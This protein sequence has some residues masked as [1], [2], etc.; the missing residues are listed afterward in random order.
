MLMYVIW[1]LDYTKFG[2]YDVIVFNMNIQYSNLVGIFFQLLEN[3]TCASRSKENQ[4][5]FILILLPHVK[6]SI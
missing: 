6:F 5:F 3:R 2:V 1:L 4:L